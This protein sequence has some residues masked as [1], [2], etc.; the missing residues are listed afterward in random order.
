MAEQQ[1][2]AERTTLKE[3]CAPPATQKKRKHIFA[4]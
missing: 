1:D 3:L 2:P 4:N